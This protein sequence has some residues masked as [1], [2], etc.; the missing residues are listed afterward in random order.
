MQAVFHFVLRATTD[1]WMDGWMDGCMDGWMDG[2]MHACMHGC[3]DAWMDA[4]MDACMDGSI[5]RPFQ[6]YML[7]QD[8]GWVLLKGCVQWNPVLDCKDPCL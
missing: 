2:C 7:Y 3:M 6:R 8:D 4:C 5:L 1:G